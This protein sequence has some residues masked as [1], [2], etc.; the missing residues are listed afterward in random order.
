ME[1]MLS[2]E[3]TK[4][5]DIKYLLVCRLNK[6]TT[7]VIMNYIKS[8]DKI[9]KHFTKIFYHQKFY[10]RFKDILLINKMDLFLWVSCAGGGF[11]IRNSSDDRAFLINYDLEALSNEDLETILRSSY[12]NKYIIRNNIQTF[13]RTKRLKQTLL[14]NNSSFLTRELLDKYFMDID[15]FQILISK[16][17]YGYGSRK[18]RK[19]NQLMES[20]VLERLYKFNNITELINLMTKIRFSEKTLLL[21]VDMLT[22]PDEQKS[23][24]KTILNEQFITES[25]IEKYAILIDNWHKVW[26]HPVSEHFIEKYIDKINWESDAEFIFE[27]KL[28]EQFIRKYFNPDKFK[29]QPETIKSLLSKNMLP[30]DL[31]K[32]IFSLDNNKRYE[33]ERIILKNSNEEYF[34]SFVQT[35]K[36][37]INDEDKFYLI[38]TKIENIKLNKNSLNQIILY[39]RTDPEF[40]KLNIYDQKDYWTKLFWDQD[41]TKNQIIENIDKLSR[42]NYIRNKNISYADYLDIKKVFVGYQSTL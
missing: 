17:K 9:R 7:N 28:S 39:L 8:N 40:C 26:F 19:Y 3:V 12:P 37:D 34:D 2:Y 35:F 14:E 10:E 29:S 16:N 22:D 21:F 36:S 27:R 38:I 4:Y 15:Y 11:S 6:N 33:Y 13:T 23:L 25:F 42:L 41:L 30:F 32:Q 24:L 5:L 31:I 1:D 18:G 20:L